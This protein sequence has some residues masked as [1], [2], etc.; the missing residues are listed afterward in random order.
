MLKILETFAADS[1]FPA[2]PNFAPVV[3]H[4]QQQLH[5]QLPQQQQQQSSPF[6]E[7]QR[8]DDGRQNEPLSILLKISL[9][10]LHLY[11]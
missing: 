9:F 1:I 11:I 5:Q 6:S 10:S 7:A 2:V 3:A 8:I 4:T